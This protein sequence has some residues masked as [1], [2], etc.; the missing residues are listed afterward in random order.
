MGGLAVFK[1]GLDTGMGELGSCLGPGQKGGP[2][3]PALSTA[4]NILE[5]YGRNLLA[6]QRPRF[7]RNVKFNNPVFRSAVDAIQ[8]GRAVLR[9]YGY[10]EEREDGLSFPD[11]ELEPQAARVAAVTAEVLLLRTE[12]NLLLANSH[13]CPKIFQDVLDGAKEG[14]L[15]P[16]VVPNPEQGPAAS[17]PLP[18]AGGP[19][20]RCGASA[21]DGS[22][23]LCS[24]CHRHGSPQKDSPAP[25]A[26]LGVSL[27][28]L[29]CLPSLSLELPPGR[30]GPVPAPRPPWRCTACGTPN[31][32]LAVLCGGCD[33]PRACPPTPGPP[34]PTAVPS[35]A[36]SA[37]ACRSCTLLNP[38][39]TV[40]CAVC[41][42]PR[43][44]GRPPLEAPA[45]P[46][47]PG[48]QCEHCTFWNQAP[49][50]VCEVCHR[51]SQLGDATP[52]P[53]PGDKGPRRL[54]KPPHLS[55]EEAERRRQDKLREDGMKLV[56]MI[57]EAEMAGVSPE[58]VEAARRYSGAEC[59]LPWLRSELPAVLGAVMEAASGQAS[60]EPGGGLGAITLGE[61]RDAWVCSHGDV[62]EAVSRCLGARRTKVRAL[63]GLGFGVGEPVLEA[64]YHNEGDL[65]GALRDLQRPVLEPFCQRLWASNEPP[66]DFHASDHQAVVRRV[67]ASQGLPSWGRAELVAS[68]A[69]ELGVGPGPGRG[70]GLVLG[71]IVEAVRASPDRAFIKRLLSWE[72]AVC[73]WALPRHQM[74]SLTSCE[75]TICPECFVQHFTIA[76]KEKHITD[77]VCPACDAPD[78]RHEPDRLAYFSTLDIQ[79]RECL[80]PETYEL[81]TK[82]LTEQELMRDPKFQ[83]CTHCSF[84]FIYE[85]EQWD[86]QCPQCR[87]SFCVHCKRPWEPQHQGLSC[88]EFL[89]WK[90]SNDPQYQAQ[91]LAAYL[92]EHGI[93]ECPEDPYSMN[94]TIQ[95]GAQENGVA[96]NTDPPAGTRPAPGGGCRVM[97]QKE[98]IAGLQDEAC[99]KETPPGHA[100]LCQ[101]HYKEYLV[102]LINTHTLDPATLYSLQELEVACRRHLS[103]GAPARLPAEPEATYHARLLQKLTTESKLSPTIPRRRL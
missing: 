56:A 91:G 41:E 87:Q 5:K 47:A 66:I 46:Q 68:L 38:P 93:S 98:T 63:R 69:Q 45:T 6:G 55:P 54:A 23:G 43:L 30:R 24:E 77:L 82:K 1:A 42:R 27:T 94:P 71:D 12:V 85:S 3:M 31:E 81:F 76:V 15:T 62:D 35:P 22:P 59:P 48:W 28:L 49:G 29:P 92:Q 19:C 11:E 100:G 72:C 90:R 18:G 60:C 4:L 86:A 7:W 73:G 97:E 20:A 84:G 96:F 36:P 34:T 44:A 26:G 50:R 58:E 101:A 2:K 57:R 9:L 13:P 67:L 25:G 37:W 70:R 33:R 78:L 103:G 83:W 16:E 95:Q 39:G 53:P 79:L 51:T 32:G 89:E 75:C 99:G 102:S 88:Q 40:L 80:D 21:P 74:Q 64:L 8:G 52:C 14:V 65:W 61:A 17:L 10:T